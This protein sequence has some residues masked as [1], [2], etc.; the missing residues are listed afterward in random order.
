M[1]SNVRMGDFSSYEAEEANS[2]TFS[3]T[4]DCQ[5]RCKYCYMVGKNNKNRMTFDVA[6]K[7]IDYILQKRDLYSC[8]AV[9]WEFIGGEPLLEIELMDRICDY[10]KQKT[11]L[12]GHPW[13]INY[14]FNISTNGLLYDDER[15]QA[16]IKKNKSHLSVG[17]SLDGN[18][19]KNDNQR[20]YKDNK[21]SYDDV[22]KNVPL[23]LEQFPGASTK[24]TFSHGDIHLLK[25]SIISLWDLG[26]E[27]VSANVVFE[28]V[29]DEQDPVIFEE[30][31]KEL[32]DYIIDN[33]LWD[34]YNVRFFDPSI[35]F[36]QNS[37]EHEG[38]FC[39]AGKMVAIDNEGTF[40]PCTRFMSF[41]LNNKPGLKIGNLIK[42]IDKNKLKAFDHLT[43]KTISPKKCLECEV[44]SGCSSCS[45][46]NYD[47]S[48]Y[49]SVFER[50]TGICEMHKA[51]VKA[52]D[53]FWERYK[54]VTN[55]ES[56][57]DRIRMLKKQEK[58]KFLQIIM[59]E[60]IKSTC[61][62]EIKN[63]EKTFLMNDEQL[64][65]SIEF[66]ENNDFKPVLIGD[67]LN[68]EQY[69]DYINITSTDSKNEDVI[70]V[71]KSEDEIVNNNSNIIIN[72]RKKDIFKIHQLVEIASKGFEYVRVNLMFSDLEEWTSSDVEEYKSQLDKLMDL[73][74][75]KKGEDK[76][77]E[78]NTLNNVN[79]QNNKV[80]SCGAGKELFAIGP[81]KKLYL[82]PAFYFNYEYLDI[83]DIKTGIN[84]DKLEIL[85][86]NI[87]KIKNDDKKGVCKKCIYA[88]KKQTNELYLSS[89]IQELITDIE[90]KKSK[91]LIEQLIG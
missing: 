31:L 51:N 20:V 50:A 18:K 73:T 17:I 22:V 24:A 45:G 85:Q 28:D 14:M 25:D 49:G 23:W 34:K 90:I 1:E 3:L 68:K 65:E 76:V 66:A 2:I 40:Y 39:G 44:A 37:D 70:K 83:G 80:Y 87:N 62:Y 82:C 56:E 74:L 78:I 48:K 86:R 4:Q 6:K 12:L 61:N 71:Y 69:K 53:Y 60:D 35:G 29:W 43:I 41:T 77:L 79:P 52:C 84:Y 26:I 72:I 46:H 33:G 30:Q 88:N 64:K 63:K 13:A 54:Q 89:E 81:N 9:Q 19:E 11:F 15:V 32:A 57:R 47:E 58:E 42:G 59:S 21:G 10:I 8:N 38:K 55:C 67:V 5:L 27:E 16:F 75:E 91:E 7:S 36:P